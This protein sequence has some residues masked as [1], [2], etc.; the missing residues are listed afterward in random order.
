M[1][2]EEVYEI[3]SLHFGLLTPE[4]IERMSVVEITKNKNLKDNNSI[5][6]TKMGASELFNQKCRTCEEDVE[7]C[8]GHFGMIRLNSNVLHPLFY[9]LS[10]ILLKIFCHSCHKLLITRKLIKLIDRNNKSF[11]DFL[12]ELRRTS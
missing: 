10:K 7:K 6:E 8:P 1:E 12:S 9:K 11:D 4:E 2:D 5:Y 3:K